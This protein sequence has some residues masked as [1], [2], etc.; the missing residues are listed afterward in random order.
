MIRFTIAL[1]ASLALAGGAFAGAA[2]AKTAKPEKTA[3]KLHR[4]HYACEGGVT[5]T[6]T[7]PPEALAKTR[8]VK[9][10]LK[11]VTYFVHPEKAAAGASYENKRIKLVFHTEGDQAT[12]E[13]EGKPLAEKCKTQP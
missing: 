6:A 12:L 3:A 10:A 4:V 8:P 5:L 2:S 1:A 11:D 13:R 9:V 7:Y